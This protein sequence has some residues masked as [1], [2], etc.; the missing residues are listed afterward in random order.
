MDDPDVAVA[1]VDRDAGHL[2]EDQLHAVFLGQRTRPARVDAEGR[3][4]GI[5]T[6]EVQAGRGERDD[7]RFHGS[8]LLRQ[9]DTCLTLISGI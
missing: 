1:L 5:R 7:Q 2:A 3:R 9:A 6:S 8:L 4:L